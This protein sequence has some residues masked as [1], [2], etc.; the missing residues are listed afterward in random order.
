MIVCVQIHNWPPMRVMCLFLKMNTFA[1]WKR[2]I[3]SQHGAIVALNT[4]KQADGGI[5]LAIHLLY[6]Y[7]CIDPQMLILDWVFI[8]QTLF[9]TAGSVNSTIAS[10]QYPEYHHRI[11]PFLSVT[12]DSGH[13]PGCP[14]PLICSFA[15][16]WSDDKQNHN[17]CFIVLLSSIHN[18]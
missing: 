9:D 10:T 16:W 15:I 8:L 11:W 4:F 12:R 14:S 5:L 2:V 6:C 17:R 18:F 7:Y 3:K 13:P 1:E